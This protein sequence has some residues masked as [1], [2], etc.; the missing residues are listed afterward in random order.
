MEPTPTK[1]SR[2]TKAVLAATT[3]LTTL[4]VMTGTAAA[5]VNVQPTE[6]GIPGGALIGRIVNG[7]AQYALW[8]CVA[9]VLAGAGFWGWANYN[10]RAA[11]V[12]KGQKMIL[13]GVV[14][15]VVVGAS[16]LIVNTAFTAGGAG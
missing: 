15:A 14:G 1:P 2:I 5:Q 9:A 16:G 3:T 7:V 6:A 13:G 12:N 11:G 4:A 10:D 8:A